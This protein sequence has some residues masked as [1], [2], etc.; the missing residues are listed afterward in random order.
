MKTT[1]YLLSDRKS[2]LQKDK[3]CRDGGRS[4]DFAIFCLPEKTEINIIQQ[5]LSGKKPENGMN[6]LSN[7]M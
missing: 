7:H 5:M 3:Y 4:F 2:I 6:S 1:K